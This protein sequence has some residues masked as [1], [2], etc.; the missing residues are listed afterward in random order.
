MRPIAIYQP[1]VSFLLKHLAIFWCHILWHIC[2]EVTITCIQE[3]TEKI[4]EMTLLKGRWT[5]VKNSLPTY[6][7]EFMEKPHVP[8]SHLQ[9]TQN[10]EI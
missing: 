2:G 1:F 6:E 7:A 9:V 10:T 4:N 5:C 8:S 3:A